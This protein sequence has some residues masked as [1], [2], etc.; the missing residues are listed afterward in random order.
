MLFWLIY[1][2]LLMLLLPIALY[3]LH[4]PRA[5]K[6]KV[7]RRALEHFGISPKTNQPVD[8]WFHAVSVGEV[9]AAAPLL[10]ALKAQHPKWQLLLTTT[11]A[12][13]AAQA[14]DKLGDIVTH[15]YA[16]FDLLPCVWLFLQ[17]HPPKQLWIMETELWPNL[18]RACARRHIPVK[19]VNARLSERSAHR[20]QKFATFSHQLLSYL[21]H[22]CVQHQDDAERF[23]DLGYPAAQLTVTGSIKYDLTLPPELRAEAQ[24][25]RKQLF[26]ERPVW[27]AAST[28]KGEDEVLLAIHKRLSAH[29]PNWRLIL[30]PRHPERF[31]AVAALIQTSGLKGVRRSLAAQPQ[32]HTQVYLGDTMG[33]LLRL[34]GMA[35]VAFMGGSIQPIGGHNFLEAAALGVPCVS[36]P[37]DFNFSDISAQLQN[38]GA[39]RREPDEAAIEAA[40]TDYM[41]NT[42]LRDA[43]AKAAHRVVQANR[44]SL[45]RTLDALSEAAINI[46]LDRSRS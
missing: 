41:T 23:M 28:H 40:L 27:I 21:S 9:L 24:A 16:P 20:Y 43:A 8:L 10:R 37:Y 1:N 29:H 17:R 12:T 46:T 11:T 25:E 3:K 35:D 19:L 15:R 7:G 36:G 31:D 22:I 45:Q 38:E 32:A 42:Q 18:L 5:G 13:G 6:P 30:V 26:G 33:E 2:L 39:L 4:W 44:G 34:Y 14:R